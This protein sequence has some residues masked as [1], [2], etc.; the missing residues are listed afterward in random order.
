MTNELEIVSP[1]ET[2][3]NFEGQQITIS[4]IR[5]GKLQAFTAAVKPVA[6]DLILALNGS[7]DLLTTIELH[8]SRLIDAVHIGS[9]VPR[10]QLENCL[11]DEFITLAAAV[12]E[13]NADFFARRLLPAVRGAI[14]GVSKTMKAGQQSF[15]A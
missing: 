8:G 12:V 9:G 14:D 1:P 7:G 11:P 13:V 5:M 4:P 2:V 10:D 3:V 6:Q 15:K